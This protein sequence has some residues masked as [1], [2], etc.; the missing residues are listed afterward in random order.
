MVL[1][2]RSG[3]LIQPVAEA[4]AANGASVEL[5]WQDEPWKI[6]HLDYLVTYGPMQS[7][8]WALR[9][10][11]AAHRVPPVVVWFTE[12]MPSPSA[13]LLISKA[14]ELRC[15][16]DRATCEMKSNRLLAKMTAKAVGK[17][18]RL[19]SLGEL[20][21]LKRHKMLR[22]VGVFSQ[23]NQRYL[24]AS[25]LPSAVIPMGYH[26]SFGHDKGLTRD[27]DVVFLGTT[28]DRRRKILIANIEERLLCRG[29]RIEIRDGSPDRPAIF[30]DERSE[31]LSRSKIMLNIMRQPWD[32]PVFRLL[33]A[34]PHGTLVLSEMLLP[35]STGPF[36]PAQHFVMSKIEE[37]DSRIA[38]LLADEEKRCSVSAKA[39]YCVMR[40]VT[41]DNMAHRLL[42][43]AGL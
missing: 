6:D 9:R 29:I 23:T 32:D 35:T 3:G 2:P 41:M 17:A 26:P 38:T 36:V 11:G 24:A 14:A 34:A 1:E 39:K 25:G 28:K 37:L 13:H 27:I 8:S 43:C 12:Q 16:S 30:G 20:L 19:R 10:L 7:M 33:L 22:M 4:L 21:F 5:L 31:L 42:C 15:A 18:G 40:E